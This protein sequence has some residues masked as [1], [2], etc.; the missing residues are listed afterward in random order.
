MGYT[1]FMDMHSGGGLKLQWQYIYIESDSQEQGITIFENMFGRDPSNVTC[2]CCGKDYSVTFS[3]D[4]A[5]ATAYERGCGYDNTARAWLEQPDSSPYRHY[6][7]VAEYFLNNKDVLRLDRDK[8]H[9]LEV[10]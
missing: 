7:T 2:Y 1:Q 4:I 6:Q 9:S 5:Q 3:E 8:T 10:D